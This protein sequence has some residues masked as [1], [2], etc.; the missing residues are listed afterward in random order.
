MPA[1]LLAEAGYP[2]GEGLPEI[3]FAMPEHIA[4]V[5]QDVAVQWGRLGARVNVLSMKA[6][7]SFDAVMDAG[8]AWCLGWAADFPDPEGLFQP[9]LATLPLYRDEEIVALLGEARTLRDQD[10]RTRLF[11]EV[12]RLLVAERCALLPL[13]Y[14]ATMLLRRH[15]VDGLSWTPLD[16]STSL[17][18]AIVRR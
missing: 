9:M 7:H 4:D 1:R 2:D 6:H 15:W 16:P 5:G 3:A 8:N 17:D 13:G 18:H 10:E 12:D 11:R 14:P